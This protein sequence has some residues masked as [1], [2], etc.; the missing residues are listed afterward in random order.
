MELW[1]HPS[2]WSLP[3]C[4]HSTLD[5]PQ[6][7]CHWVL[8]LL[9]LY[10]VDSTMKLLEV[11]TPPPN[12]REGEMKEGWRT[13]GGQAL[14]CWLLL[15]RKPPRETT[16][17]FGDWCLNRTNS[18]KGRPRSPIKAASQCSFNKASHSL[19]LCSLVSCL[20][21]L[22]SSLCPLHSA[23]PR[24]HLPAPSSPLVHD[25]LLQWLV[26]THSDKHSRHNVFSLQM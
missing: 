26:L 18:S 10:P 22:F 7:P 23:T 17:S 24:H 9:D 21:K 6:K 11:I 12:S 3:Q 20:T 5:L 25:L 19:D 1:I 8:F 16:G 13:T 15:P 14:R 2:L 4:C